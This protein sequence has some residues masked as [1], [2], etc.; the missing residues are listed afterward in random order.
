ME[1]IY[2][3][4]LCREL[5]R[6]IYEVLANINFDE[7]VDRAAIK[8]LKD[9]QDVMQDDSIPEEIKAPYIEEAL[10]RNGIEGSGDYE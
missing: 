7:L 3:D 5:E 4:L 8:A 10:I 6:C 9:I 1:E 2:K